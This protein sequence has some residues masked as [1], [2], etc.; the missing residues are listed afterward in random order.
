MMKTFDAF[1]ERV[2]IH[3]RLRRRDICLNVVEDVTFSALEAI[4]CLEALAGS[5][6]CP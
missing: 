6:N 2:D 3:V 4:A 5:A 1:C